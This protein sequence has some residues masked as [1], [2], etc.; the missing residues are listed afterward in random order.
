MRLVKWKLYSTVLPNGVRMTGSSTDIGRLSVLVNLCYY[1]MQSDDLRV[2]THHRESDHEVDAGY[3]VSMYH[4][5][6]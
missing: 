6:I 5:L 1:F 2:Q 4:T 3:L